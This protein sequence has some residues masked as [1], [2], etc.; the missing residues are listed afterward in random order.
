MNPAACTSIGPVASVSPRL[1]AATGSSTVDPLAGAGADQAS[2]RSPVSAST[3]NAVTVPS[4]TPAVTRPVST[5][6][7]MKFGSPSPS[8]SKTRSIS[9]VDWVDVP[10]ACEAANTSSRSDGL[11][12]RDLPRERLD[13]EVGQVGDLGIGRV[14][15]RIGEQPGV[16]VRVT[17]VHAGVAQRD[18]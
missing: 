2:T 8:V 12:P 18:R 15:G 10:S 17:G 9:W 16:D 4:A 11:Q 6:N 3:V 13:A 7:V 5:A 1:L 14:A